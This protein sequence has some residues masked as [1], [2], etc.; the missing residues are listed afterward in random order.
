MEKGN[1]CSI[2][3]IK[4]IPNNKVYVGSSKNIKSRLTK[5]KR[6]LEYNCHYCKQMQS[7]FNY[8]GESC[9]EFKIIQE[10]EINDRRIYEMN[11]INKLKMSH[12]IYNTNTWDNYRVVLFKRVH[13]SERAK[14]L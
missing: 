10:C 11:A 3:T 12:E 6:E 9:F 13:N 1:K 8:Y 2:Y 4:C 5:H 7:D 14:K